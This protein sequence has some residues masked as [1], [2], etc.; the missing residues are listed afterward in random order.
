MQLQGG[1]TVGS[2]VILLMDATTLLTS[3]AWASGCAAIYSLGHSNI[4]INGGATGSATAGNLI[5]GGT[6]QATGNGTGLPYQTTS[7]GIA[8]YNC[9]NCIFKNITI[10]N[11]YV[12]SS[13]SDEGG[14]PTGAIYVDGGSNLLITNNVAH[15]MK[16]CFEHLF[17]NG[18]SNVIMSNNLAYN[19]DHG[20][21]EAPASSPGFILSSVYIFGNT[22]HDPS[23]WDDIANNN[24]H[25]GIHEW[26]FG[27]GNSITASY[28][29]NNYFYGNFGT[30]FTS[31]IFHQAFSL[32]STDAVFN[33][34][35]APIGGAGGNGYIGMGSN[36]GGGWLLANNTIIGYST[37]SGIGFNSNGSAGTAYNNI[38]A[39]V[40][41]AMYTI[42]GNPMQAIDYQDYYNIGSGGWSGGGPLSVWQSYC[43]S[44][45]PSTVGCDAHAISANPS[46]GPLYT[47]NSGAPVN[48]AGKNL[49]GICSGQ[50]NP[51]L[52]ALC[53]DKA[54]NP[55]PANGPWSTGA[56]QYNSA[57]PNPPTFLTTSVR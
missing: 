24:H 15:D 12:H 4:T 1:G 56:Y 42:G 57:P 16:W 31:A 41:S 23:N 20:F 53:Y 32:G 8:M 5:G 2:P 43:L 21:V 17:N 48:L 36:G 35:V 52:G 26:S 54:G 30:N 50:A 45:F 51:G 10:S 46:L 49:S 27:V 34:V 38:I 19:V 18:D 3:P 37:A 40:N 11:I 28:N 6:I 44:T 13:V 14:D 7:A 39:T 9:T 33:N 22:F 47:P 55:R 25:D 29:Y